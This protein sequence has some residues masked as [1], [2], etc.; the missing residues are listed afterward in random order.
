MRT[1]SFVAFAQR[2]FINRQHVSE[3]K[4]RTMR[5]LKSMVALAVLGFGTPVYASWIMVV[6]DRV[7]YV[8]NQDN[9]TYLHLKDDDVTDSSP[10]DN[11]CGGQGIF[12]PIS[13]PLHDRAF[14]LFNT[15]FL[16]ERRLDIRVWYC[17]AN[18][19]A[20]PDMISVQ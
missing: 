14:V 6:R 20:V 10:V 11:T 12:I 15:E 17:D 7:E 4:G 19:Y 8:R 9:G 18:G 16:T 2:F 3:K 1:T 13:H 5:F